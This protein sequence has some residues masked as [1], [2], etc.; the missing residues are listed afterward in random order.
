MDAYKA[1]YNA[2]AMASLVCLLIALTFT[3]Q[4]ALSRLNAVAQCCHLRTLLPLNLPVD[5][6][7]ERSYAPRGHETPYMLLPSPWLIHV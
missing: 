7:V 1:Q 2:I 6:I 5:G 4:S 3:V